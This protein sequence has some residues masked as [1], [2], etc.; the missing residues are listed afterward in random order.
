MSLP[1]DTVITHLN[2]LVRGFRHSKGDQLQ[3]RCSPPPLE[4][5]IPWLV[6]LFRLESP[7]LLY[8]SAYLDRLHHSRR[9]PRGI[10]RCTSHRLAL[11]AIVVAHK[12]LRDNSYTNMDWGR[13]LCISKEEMDRTERA[14]LKLL[15]WNLRVSDEEL[16][17]VSLAVRRPLTHPTRLKKIRLRRENAIMGTRAR[18][19]QDIVV[20]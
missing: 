15:G 17:A 4:D 12:Y 3:C 13:G 14:M 7:E 9:R 18:M 11:A 16:Q 19:V 10:Q 6:R 2:R 5:Y 8:A 1:V 20:V